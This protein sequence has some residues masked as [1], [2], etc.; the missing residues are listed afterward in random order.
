MQNLENMASISG[1][2]QCQERQ[3]RR[4]TCLAGQLAKVNITASSGVGF[5][6]QQLQ[7]QRD[8]QTSS[9]NKL[10]ASGS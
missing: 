5:R 3:R 8:D 1:K 4:I 6:G 10:T 2:H 7:L 9:A